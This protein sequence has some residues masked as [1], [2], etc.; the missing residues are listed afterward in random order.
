MNKT[1]ELV[2]AWSAFEEQFPAG[3]T[4]DF[5]R[6]QLARR[7]LQAEGPGTAPAGPGKAGEGS[8]KG[9]DGPAKGGE[10]AGKGADGPGK[11]GAFHMPTESRLMRLIG[12][13]ARLH[14]GYAIAALDGTP[15]NSIEEF[16]LQQE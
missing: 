3:T 15:L 5:C 8:G 2:N 14:A 6:H 9:A 7:Q 10:G 13:I 12:R 16:G 4:D 11:G 1:V